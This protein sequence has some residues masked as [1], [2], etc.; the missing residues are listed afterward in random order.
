M[1][2]SDYRSLRSSVLSVILVWR[3]SW[4]QCVKEQRHVRVLS[5][6]KRCSHHLDRNLK[7]Q[8]SFVISISVICSINSF[9]LFWAIYRPLYCYCENI[10][11]LLLGELIL[12]LGTNDQINIF[13]RGF[14]K[15]S[16]NDTNEALTYLQMDKTSRDHDKSKRWVRMQWAALL[17]DFKIC[18]LQYH[19]RRKYQCICRQQYIWSLLL[20]ATVFDAYFLLNRVYSE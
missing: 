8:C 4:Y 18:D 17:H 14:G 3:M 16:T 20:A 5:S 19:R 11:R 13:R 7:S 1:V 2:P 10:W 6:P 9:F 12:K 15:M